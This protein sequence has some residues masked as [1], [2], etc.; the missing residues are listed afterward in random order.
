M[1]LKI[2]NLNLKRVKKKKKKKNG[3]DKGNKTLI[4]LSHN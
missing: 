1:N 4:N 3:N 2:Y